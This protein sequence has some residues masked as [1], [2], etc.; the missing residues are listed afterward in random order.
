[1]N[2]DPATVALLAERMVGRT[3]PAAPPRIPPLSA[4]PG[5]GGEEVPYGAALGW[6]VAAGGRRG[7]GG[8]GGGGGVRN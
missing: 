3:P 2:P 4:G 5:V 7:E 1:M 6:A 8:A